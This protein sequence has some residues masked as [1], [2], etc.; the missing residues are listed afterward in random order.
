MKKINPKVTSIA[1]MLISLLIGGAY[2]VQESI[3]PG[4]E[5]IELDDAGGGG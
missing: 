1:V 2:A 4:A 5:D 3:G